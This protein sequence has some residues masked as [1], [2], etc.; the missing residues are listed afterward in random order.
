MLCEH[1]TLVQ[2]SSHGIGSSTL[3]DPHDLD[4]D[5]EPGVG[6]V[7]VPHTMRGHEFLERLELVLLPVGVHEVLVEYDDGSADDARCQR[8]K[9]VPGRR[10]DIAI[11]VKER[12]WTLVSR[13]P[14]RN[15]LAEKSLMGAERSRH[16]GQLA[17]RIE[18]RRIPAPRVRQAD[19]AV[20]TVNLAARQALR[21]VPNR[22]T[23]V[24]AALEIVAIDRDVAQE[25][26]P[27]PAAPPSPPR[28]L[29][30]YVRRT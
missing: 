29:R 10:V 17:L 1:N 11:D 25:R 24:D 3:F 27:E 15:R 18:A 26:C 19:E 6:E 5:L 4:D 30:S 21:N 28:R 22:P 9:D 14:G 16:S 13:Q 7:L 12:H 23:L 2:A 8:L 20:E